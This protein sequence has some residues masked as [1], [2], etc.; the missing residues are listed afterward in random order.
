VSGS[1]SRYIHNISYFSCGFCNLIFPSNHVL[2]VHKEDSNHW[3]DDGFDEETDSEEEEEDMH[4]WR[5][6]DR[7]L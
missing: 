6:I 7:L 2:N 3:S 4:R 1:F 5:E